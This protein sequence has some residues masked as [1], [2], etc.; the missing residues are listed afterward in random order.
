MLLNNLKR[1]RKIKSDIL[2]KIVI[3]KE[4]EYFN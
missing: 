2:E 4:V 3:P 1:N